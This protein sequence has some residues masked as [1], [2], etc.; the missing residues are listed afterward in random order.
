MIARR[1]LRWAGIAFA[2]L[3]VLLFVGVGSIWLWARPTPPDAFYA[4]PAS[5]PF[6]P[7][8]LIR[9]EA[10][11]RG[12]PPGARGWRILYGT[13]RHDGR[14]AVASALVV[15]PATAGA[16][17][18]RVVA[19]THG[20][21]G[22]EP[23]CAPSLLREPF[24]GMGAIPRALE[25][26]WAIVATDYEGL[27]TA[28]PHPYLIGQGEARSA[29][30]SIRAARRLPG[31]RL[32]DGVVVWGHSQGGGAALWTGLIAPAYAPDVRIAGVAAAA[33]ASDLPALLEEVQHTVVG[34]MLS[35]YVMRAYADAYP[36][37][38]F[39][40]YVRP[41]V[42]PLAYDMA[43]RCMSDRRALVSA[44]EAKAAGGSLFA[45][46]PSLGPLGRRLAE[47]TPQGRLAAPVLIAQGLADDLVLP[48]VQ[49]RFVAAWRAQGQEVDYRTYAGRDHLSLL[50]PD[51]PFTSELL[52]WTRDR[53]AEKAEGR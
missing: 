23:G 44:I 5:S 19:W 50:A 42:R 27:G 30:D 37:V 51:A 15:V 40:G 29:L 2:A 36:D 6:Q 43:S 39:D 41:L 53:F 1:L 24:A 10:F 25:Q 34:R 7:G 52:A 48:T 12:A 21:T 20:T 16:A 33:P 14:P 17:P 46:P 9:A 38:T 32:A 35:S 22:V 49:D 3:A 8:A 47:N 31:Q 11:G 28:G 18:L 13:T 45:R 4:P 26:G